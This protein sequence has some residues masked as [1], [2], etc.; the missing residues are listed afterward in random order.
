MAPTV[1]PVAP[2]AS[3]IVLE[4]VRMIRPPAATPS[5]RAA[6]FLTSQ[7]AN[8]AAITPPARS[9]S[10]VGP[11][12][13]LRAE[14]EDEAQ[15]AADRDHELRGVDRADHLA[16]LEPARGEQRGG[17]DRAPAAAADGVEGAADQAHRGQHRDRG[18][19]P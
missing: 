5:T 12:D 3:E 6:S 18:P 8:G 11:H 14:R 15:R 7:A 16:G 17:A 1:P 2:S 19:R 10:G 9:A 13:A 4:L